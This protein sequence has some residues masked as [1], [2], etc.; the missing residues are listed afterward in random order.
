M[1]LLEQNTRPNP[2]FIPPEGRGLLAAIRG[3]EASGQYDVIYGGQ[4]FNDYS[5]HPHISVPIASGPNKG[6]TS[7]AAGAYQFLGPTWDDVSSRYGLKDFSPANQDYGAWMLANEVYHR[8]TGGDLTEALHAGKLQDVAHAL[9]GTWT[10]LAGGIE[11]QPGGTGKGLLANY[12]NGMGQI[13]GSAPILQADFSETGIDQPVTPIE[14]AA[15]GYD[16]KAL[17]GLLASLMP[18]ERDQPQ[19]AEMPRLQAPE[20]RSAPVSR[21]RGMAFRQLTIKTRPFR[22]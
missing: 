7:S 19:E 17:R 8:K 3:P 16:G 13:A 9:S 11:A 21:P 18:S 14:T 10:S 15:P 12:Q 6:K 2:G 20:A 22:R 4:H 5:N 1:A